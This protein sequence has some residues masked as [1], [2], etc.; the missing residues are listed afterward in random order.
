MLGD[1]DARSAQ[2]VRDTVELRDHRID[3]RTELVGDLH[4]AR[5]DPVCDG[6]AELG[7]GLDRGSGG[8]EPGVTL[9]PVH[10]VLSLSFAFAATVPYEPDDQRYRHDC[11]EDQKAHVE[12]CT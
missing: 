9:E 4:G 2:I 5:S 1:R 6:P 11:Q 7:L 10:S 12:D 3:R 8:F